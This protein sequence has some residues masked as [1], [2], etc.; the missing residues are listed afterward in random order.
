M[1]RN[2]YRNFLR[3]LEKWPL[4]ETKKG[5]RD[6]GE[7]LRI[8]VSEAFRLGDAT[9]TNE[10]ECQRA[11]AS[12]N[13]LA[14]NTYATKYPRKLTSTSTGVSIEECHQIVSTDFLKAIEESEAGMLSGMFKQK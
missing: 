3:L 10:T 13:R 6:L 12:L 5:G 1:A 11:Y 14:N 7:H 9:P 2:S 8:R 4:D